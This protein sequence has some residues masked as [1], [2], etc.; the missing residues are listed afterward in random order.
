MFSLPLPGGSCMKSHGLLLSPVQQGELVNIL[1]RAHRQN[2]RHTGTQCGAS[3]PR[4]TVHLYMQTIWGFWIWML[5]KC[6]ISCPVNFLGRIQKILWRYSV[7]AQNKRTGSRHHH[8]LMTAKRLWCCKVND[9]TWLRHWWIRRQREG[10]A[11]RSAAEAP[12]SGRTHCDTRCW[13]N[14]GQS[15]SPVPS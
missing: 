2:N 13:S 11:V 15:V 5:H 12:D 10:S 9:V 8:V 1:C 14:R 4:T 6:E 3:F 7:N